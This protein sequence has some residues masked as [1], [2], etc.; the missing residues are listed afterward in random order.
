[1]F[2]FIHEVSNGKLVLWS[3]LKV[4]FFVRLEQPSN[5][6]D[7]DDDSDGDDEQMEI[8]ITETEAEVFSLKRQLGKASID[9]EGSDVITL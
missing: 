4:T 1:M 7:S 8:S 2:P 5:T 9:G 3:V 6:N